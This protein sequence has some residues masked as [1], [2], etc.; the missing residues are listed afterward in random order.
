MGS[1]RSLKTKILTRLERGGEIGGENPLSR[2]SHNLG[3]F[4][5]DVKA[6]V[7]DLE[8]EG[9]ISVERS[10]VGAVKTI[11]YRGKHPTAPRHADR[12]EMSPQQKKERTFAKGVPAYLPD[13]WC[14]PV[15]VTH[16]DQVVAAVAAAVAS[17][18]QEGKE[19]M[20]AEPTSGPEQRPYHELLTECLHAL[21]QMA[22]ESG[23]AKDTSIRGVLELLPG[24]TP[25]RVG[26]AMEHLHGMELYSTQMTGFARSSYQLDMSRDAVSAEM[27]QEYRSR[28]SASTKPTDVADEADGSAL[29]D[30][31][32]EELVSQL[33]GIIESQE[34]TITTL[35]ATVSTQAEELTGLQGEVQRLTSQCEELAAKQQSGVPLDSRVASILE[36]H[37]AAPRT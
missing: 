29:S 4:H 31:T 28:D 18:P 15:V 17:S 26:R 33:A 21:R 13:D 34:A 19:D 37:A 14:T 10:A 22:D 3:E 5:R 20:P 32:A 27:V 12:T 36:R 8:R 6:T 9:R 30:M 11:A 25:H 24:M 23:Y 2:L 1:R 16:R 7:E 35:R